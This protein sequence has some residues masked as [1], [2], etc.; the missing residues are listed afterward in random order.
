MYICERNHI[1][2]FAGMAKDICGNGTCGFSK[3]ITEDIIKLQVGNGQTVSGAVF[4]AGEHVDGF[5]AVPHGTAELTD[6]KG[7]DKAGLIMLHINR[8]QIHFVSLRSVLLPH[9]G[10]VYIG[11]SCYGRF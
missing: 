6:R 2:C 8:S 11:S 3:G 10:F 7:R 4:L 1:E 9:W 5:E